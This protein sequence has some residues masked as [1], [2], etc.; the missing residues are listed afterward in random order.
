MEV[1]CPRESSFGQAV[2]A[3]GGAVIRCGLFDGCDMGAATGVRRAMHLLRLAR[4]ER[5][6]L[7]PPCT[8]DCPTQD[9]SQKTETQKRQ[10]ATR[11][12]QARRMQRGWLCEEAK[13]I[14]DCHAEL[15][16]PWTGRSWARSPSI[17]KMRSEMHETI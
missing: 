9:L 5:L 10:L 17:K 12:R 16:Q 2:E 15:E 4:P 13:K 1:C 7:S 14:T 3:Q 8:A 6:V 11:V